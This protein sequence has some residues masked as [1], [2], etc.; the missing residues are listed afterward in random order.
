V[1]GM[2]HGTFVKSDFQRTSLQQVWHILVFAYNTR[3]ISYRWALFFIIQVGIFYFMLKSGNEHL[4]RG[5]LLSISKKYCTRNEFSRSCNFRCLRSF[6]SSPAR[7]DTPW[8][9]TQ[10]AP[11][12][13]CERLLSKA[14][15]AA[16]LPTIPHWLRVVA[17]NTALI[18]VAGPL[19]FGPADETGFVRRNTVV[20]APLLQRIAEIFGADAVSEAIARGAEQKAG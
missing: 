8:L 3:V 19:F 7:F 10:Q 12:V 5:T 4:G 15:K 16:N 18:A 11:I 13:L 6:V 2:C 9:N 17:T 20:A 1:F 14:W